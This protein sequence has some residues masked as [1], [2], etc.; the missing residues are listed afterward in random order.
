MFLLVRMDIPFRTF[1]LH[2]KVPGLPWE[3]ESVGIPMGIPTF[4]YGM[5]MGMTLSLWGFPHVGIYGNLWE[6]VGICGNLWES[7]VCPVN[8]PESSSVALT[9]T[10]MDTQDYEIE[11]DEDILCSE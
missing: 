3:W 1:T 9:S 5:G 6:S 10:S 4:P 2:N 11:D 8:S 7:L